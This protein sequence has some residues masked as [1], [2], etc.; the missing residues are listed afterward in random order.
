MEYGNRN[1][2]AWDSN[3]DYFIQA[4]TKKYATF[5]GRARRA[6]FWMFTLISALISLALGILDMVLGWSDG[7]GVFSTI[8]GLAVLLPTLAVAVR[9][10]HDTDR[11]GW[12]LLIGLVPF[13]GWIV[14]LIFYIQDS[15]PGVN[16]FGPNPKTEFAAT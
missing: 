15:D 8:F 10:L 14:L 3:V 9:R 12:W 7:Y 1:L 6:E 13:V 11:S 16:R 2:V 5:S 4:V